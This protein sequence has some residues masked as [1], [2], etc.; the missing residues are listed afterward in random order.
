[1][2]LYRQETILQH[3]GVGIPAHHASSNGVINAGILIQYRINLLRAQRL[4]WDATGGAQQLDGVNEAIL[5]VDESPCK[6]WTSWDKS[7][8]IIP[9]CLNIRFIQL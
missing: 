2:P 8:W 9:L 5:M 1:M 4:V 7:R 6:P 3:I